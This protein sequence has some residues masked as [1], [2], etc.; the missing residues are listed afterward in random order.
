M[1]NDDKEF[2]VMVDVSHFTPE[3]I[4]VKT[5]DNRLVITGKHEEKQ[6]EHGFIK[7]EFTRQYLLPKVG[8]INYS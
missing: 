5:S 7:R 4:S 8:I 2:K 3:E 1:V 6:D